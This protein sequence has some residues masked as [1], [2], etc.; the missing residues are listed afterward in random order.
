MCKD[1]ILLILKIGYNFYMYTLL[2]IIINLSAYDA[3]NVTL[4]NHYD[5]LSNCQ[6]KIH[7]TYKR[8]IQA[9]VNAILLKDQHDE[10]FLKISLPEQEA[11]TYWHCKKAIFYEVTK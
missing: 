10:M 6:E 2:Q 8:N 4:L 7:Q 3:S 5:S 11:L 1:N 9:G